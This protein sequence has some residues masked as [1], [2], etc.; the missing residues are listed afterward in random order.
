M[1]TYLKHEPTDSHNSMAVF[2]DDD[3]RD[4]HADKTEYEIKG[5]NY[6]G[7]HTV[8]SSETE[9]HVVEHLSMSII[10]SKFN[11]NTNTK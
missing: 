5:N 10:I 3:A 9:T 11:E 1:F 4:R 8:V 2:I 7:T 6:E